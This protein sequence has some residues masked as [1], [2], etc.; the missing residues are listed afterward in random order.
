MFLFLITVSEGTCIRTTATVHMPPDIFPSETREKSTGVPMSTLFE[1]ETPVSDAPLV[2]AEPRMSVITETMSPKTSPKTTCSAPIT[3]VP[4][5]KDTVDFAVSSSTFALNSASSTLLL[6]SS[7]IEQIII[8]A[9]QENLISDSISKKEASPVVA[10]FSCPDEQLISFEEQDDSR[11][12]E[13]SLCVVTPVASPLPLTKSANEVTHVI[14]VHKSS[15]PHLSSPSS[16]KISPT[17]QVAEKSV[18]VQGRSS[19][20]LMSFL[21]SPES[22]HLTLAA[23]DANQ[24]VA[25]DKTCSSFG[26]SPFAGFESPLDRDIAR[27]YRLSVLGKDLGTPCASD[28]AATSGS[29]PSIRSTNEPDQSARVSDPSS[30]VPTATLTA[31]RLSPIKLNAEGTGQKVQPDPS[32]PFDITAPAAKHVTGKSSQSP[33]TPEQRSN[34]DNV[35]TSAAFESTPSK[36]S[37]TKVSVE[38]RSFVDCPSPANKFH[39]LSHDQSRTYSRIRR[40]IV[41]YTPSPTKISF[42]ESVRLPSSPRSGSPVLQSSLNALKSEEA[43]EM[44]CISSSSSPATNSEKTSALVSPSVSTQSGRRT[45]VTSPQSISTDRGQLSPA[46]ARDWRTPEKILSSQ[47]SVRALSTPSPRNSSV[48]SSPQMVRGTSSPETYDATY[49]SHAGVRRLRKGSA[50]SSR[51]SSPSSKY[52]DVTLTEAQDEPNSDTDDD[53]RS[54][55]LVA[56]SPRRSMRLARRLSTDSISLDAVP[57]EGSE[58]SRSPARPVSRKSTRRSSNRFAGFGVSDPATHEDD[59]DDNASVKSAASAAESVSSRASTVSTRSQTRKRSSFTRL[60]MRKSSVRPS[61]R[62]LQ[63][64]LSD[65]ELTSPT[66]SEIGSERQNIVV[67]RKYAASEP[68]DVSSGSRRSKRSRTSSVASDEEDRLS[69]GS[70]KPTKKLRKRSTKRQSDKDKDML[71]AGML[72]SP[73]PQKSKSRR[74]VSSTP[75]KV[76]HWLMEIVSE[77]CGE[78][79]RFLAF[80]SFLFFLRSRMHHQLLL[81]VITR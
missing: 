59:N 39:E 80:F 81:S 25:V 22:S 33:R 52:S 51:V 23:S 2:D 70:E 56:P 9:D 28:L 34:T 36:E 43:Q 12:D 71:N 53:Q 77:L 17:K 32:S 35:P 27:K 78:F 49:N 69:T 67:E 55:S 16:I 29:S 60:E 66:K 13:I 74:L 42:S 21:N 45:P 14:E 61:Y 57:E 1:Q 48:T 6:Q 37:M 58:Y 8:E 4:S 20:H 11:V 75:M 10:D 54:S 63:V 76:K 73:T 18:S 26:G 3:N 24:S 68:G 72:V 19:P 44:I 30:S 15:S 79:F 7:G 64:I 46:T 31:S 47:S 65:E 41:D 50:A 5:S 38:E 62:P 40:P